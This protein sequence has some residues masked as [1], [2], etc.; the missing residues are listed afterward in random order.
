MTHATGDNPQ[1]GEGEVTYGSYLMVDY[2]KGRR[3]H[4]AA[5][6]TTRGSASVL[7][8]SVGYRW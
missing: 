7:P 2:L 1:S 8:S 3:K 6:V 4:R 5:A